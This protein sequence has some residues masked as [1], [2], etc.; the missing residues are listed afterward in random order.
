MD[1]QGSRGGVG[2]AVT[3]SLLSGPH[4]FPTKQS[5]PPFAPG[6][7]ARHPPF[8]RRLA[9]DAHRSIA[10]ASDR[11]EQLDVPAFSTAIRTPNVANPIFNPSHPQGILLPKEERS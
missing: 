4:G 1:T 11:W 9:D 5:V 2:G 10:A 6:G 3:L 7:E 8:T